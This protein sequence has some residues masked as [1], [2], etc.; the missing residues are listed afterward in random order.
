MKQ[1]INKE[2]KE[3]ADRNKERERERERERFFPGLII[4]FS[5]EQQHQRLPW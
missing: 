3:K 4:S 2:K 5:S 1:K